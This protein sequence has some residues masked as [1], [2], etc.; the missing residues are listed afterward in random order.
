MGTGRIRSLLG[1]IAR[2][3]GFHNENRVL[4]ALR[5][6]EDFAPPDWF[7]QAVKAKKEQDAKGVDVIIETKDAGKIFLQIKS[8][9][10][11]MRNFLEKHAGKMIGVVVVG[12][13]DSDTDIRRKVF[14]E[15]NRLRIEIFEKRN[16]T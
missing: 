14:S 4:R 16:N 9:R 11:G 2:E 7:I 5:A 6:S 1:G 8:S 10:A 3:R 12:M 15:V 13:H